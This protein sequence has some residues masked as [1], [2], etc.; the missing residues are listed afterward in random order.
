MKFGE[1][2]ELAVI[3]NLDVLIDGFFWILTLTSKLFLFSESFFS[4]LLVSFCRFLLSLFGGFHGSFLGSP[5]VSI[6]GE[7]S[8][9]D[10]ASSCV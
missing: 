8:H 1:S 2:S 6:G 5:P 4:L 7:E 10:E 9:A 3:F